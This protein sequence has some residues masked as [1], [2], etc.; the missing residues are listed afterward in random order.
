MY[1]ACSWN[2]SFM[3][4]RFNSVWFISHLELKQCE[5][6][7]HCSYLCSPQSVL[8]MFKNNALPVWLT[9]AVVA[10]TAWISTLDSAGAPKSTLSIY[11]YAAKSQCW[12]FFWGCRIELTPTVSNTGLSYSAYVNSVGVDTTLKLLLLYVCP[13]CISSPVVVISSPMLMSCLVSIQTGA[14][15]WSHALSWACSARPSRSYL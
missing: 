15:S 11:L 7:M 5:L 13:N 3:S 2:V 12:I 6:N 9:E 14:L 8:G 1:S 10:V 4:R